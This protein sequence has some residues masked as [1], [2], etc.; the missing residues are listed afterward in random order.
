MQGLR[1]ARYGA[2]LRTRRQFDLA[3]KTTRRALQRNPFDPRHWRLLRD[4]LSRQGRG[5]RRG[6]GDQLASVAADPAKHL[7]VDVITI[8]PIR[9]SISISRPRR[10]CARLRSRLL[11]GDA[12]DRSSQP[13]EVLAVNLLTDGH[14]DMSGLG[15][16]KD[17]GTTL[18]P[19][20][21]AAR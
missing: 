7:P 19:A 10:R 8:R 13:I 20:P 4:Y 18:R 1:R 14:H 15:D 5:G 3:A 6:C 16:S 2:R 17:Y 11:H 12:R 21:P 9:C